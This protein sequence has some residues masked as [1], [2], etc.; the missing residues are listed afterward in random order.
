M[1]E[2][3]S[4][5]RALVLAHAV[6][7]ARQNSVIP[8]DAEAARRIGITAN[9]MKFLRRLVWLAPDLQAA[10]LDGSLDVAEYRL[11]DVTR[12]ACWQDQHQA[13]KTTTTERVMH[14]GSTRSSPTAL[15]N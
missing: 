2:R 9:H 11:R 7:R 15:G 8:T 14:E 4:A 3:S 13:L 12:H 10:V 1:T 5:Y 6:D